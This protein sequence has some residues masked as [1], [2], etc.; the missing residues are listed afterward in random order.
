MATTAMANDSKCKCLK[1]EIQRYLT[2]IA[3]IVCTLTANLAY[4][5]KNGQSAKALKKLNSE[6]KIFAQ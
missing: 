6:L 1:F 2:L 4:R 3:Q 5:Y